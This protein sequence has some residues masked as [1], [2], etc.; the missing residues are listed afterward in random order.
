MY[1][2]ESE[3]LSKGKKIDIGLGSSGVHVPDLPPHAS[4]LLLFLFSILII[5]P[6]VFMLTSGFV[7]GL[8]S[9]SGQY[10]AEGGC[11]LAIKTFGKYIYNSL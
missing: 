8:Y 2:N 7:C 5:Y 6:I 10:A 9:I 1:S 4:Y 11:C 3:I